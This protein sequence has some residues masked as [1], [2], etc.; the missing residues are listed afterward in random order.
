[1]VDERCL[2]NQ[3]EVAEAAADSGSRTPVAACAGTSASSGGGPL[4]VER[5]AVL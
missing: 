3:S 5:A 2:R 1:V 4:A